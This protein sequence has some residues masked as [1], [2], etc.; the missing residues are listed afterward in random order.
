[1]R[2]FGWLAD[3]VKADIPPPVR[4]RL[5]E[6]TGRSTRAWLGPAPEREVPG[7]TG[8][9]RTWRLFVNVPHEELHGSVGLGRRKFLR[10]DS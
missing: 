2:R 5:L 6:L 4:E 8:Y 10:K 3:H 1:V 9:D 7:A